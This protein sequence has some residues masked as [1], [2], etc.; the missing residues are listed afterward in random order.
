MVQGRVRGGLWS[1]KKLRVWA[2]I[3]RPLE[4]Q[5]ANVLSINRIVA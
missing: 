4:L 2:T 1:Q 5:P 3:A